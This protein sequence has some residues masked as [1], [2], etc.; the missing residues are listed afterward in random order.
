MSPSPVVPPPPRNTVARPLLRGV[1]HEVAF[2]VFVPLTA[3]AIGAARP[4][5]P[6]LLATVYGVCILAMFGVS[7]LY[8]RGNWAPAARRRMKRLD[9][10]TIFL[11][12]AGTYTPVTALRLPER[13]AA[14]V[15]VVV[16]GGG[17]AGVCI[18]MLWIDAPSALVA[19]VYVV[20]G[21]TALL[22][23]PSFVT[24]LGRE[25]FSLVAVGGVLYTLGA[26]V[27]A[28]R[29]PDPIPRV[30]GFHEVFHSLVIVAALA[31]YAVVLQVVSS[32]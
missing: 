6:R 5:T 23:L 26:V 24:A 7:A 2:F 16:W 17:A 10:S 19:L 1:L 3:V 28:L 12:I 15:L 21:W 18:R 9:H 32:P 22:A 30:F 13:A 8:H 29:R 14:L 11:A 31:H 27:Y 4:G 20:V 25:A